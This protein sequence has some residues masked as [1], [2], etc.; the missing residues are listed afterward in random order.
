MSDHECPVQPWFKFCETCPVKSCKYNNPHTKTKCLA[1]DHKF[2]GGDKPIS[3]AELQIFKFRDS[4]E[5]MTPRS[6]A[7]LRKQITQK[8]VN[9]TVL[10]FFIQYLEEEFKEKPLFSYVHGT[11]LNL[12]KALL[13]SSLRF[14]RLGYKQWMLPLL[15]STQ[16]WE[17]FCKAQ[18][19]SSRIKHNNIF[20]L[21]PKEFQNFQ[22]EVLKQ[23]HTKPIFRR[24]P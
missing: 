24:K 18:N 11:S 13:R 6:I 2:P 12:D 14:K 1:L 7:T 23:Q 8:V 20:L 4:P 9:V 19:I 16:T 3:D 15:T 5:D 21:R 10:F 22:Q 17:A